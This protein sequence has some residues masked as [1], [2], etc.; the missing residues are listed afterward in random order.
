MKKMRVARQKP[1]PD[2]TLIAAPIDTSPCI[3][4]ITLKSYLFYIKANL[5]RQ[6]YQVDLKDYFKEGGAYRN[7]LSSTVAAKVRLFCLPV[8]FGNRFSAFE[9]LKRVQTRDPHKKII[10]TGPFARIF[11]R[12]ILKKYSPDI[13]IMDDPE[14][15]LSR[16]LS[17]PITD[18]RLSTIENIAYRRGDRI[19][20]NPKRTKFDINRLPFISPLFFKDGSF[21]VPLLTSRGCPYPCKFCDKKSFWGEGMRLR[22]IDNVIEE[23]RFLRRRFGVRKVFFDDCNFVMTKKRTLEFCRKMNN[24]TLGVSWNCTTRVDTVDGS[25]LKL[26]RLAG[27]ETV[28]F[29]VESGSESVLKNIGKD[30][31]V[32]AIT[33]AVQSARAAGLKIGIFLMLGCPGE[34][35]KT[36]QETIRLLREIYPFD[37]LNINPMVILPGTGFCEDLIKKKKIDE[38]FFMEKKDI[39]FYNAPFIKSF[40]KGGLLN[41]FSEVILETI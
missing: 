25:L 3:N 5:E 23:I 27:C 16:I 26:M 17:K 41:K 38:G 11:Y 24:A 22:S 6:G 19:I 35:K 36:F 20:R 4:L 1:M 21:P 10:L 18:R 8:F 15:I 12:E 31:P 9:F 7:F 29:G 13:I 2:I 40:K 32:S 14:F 33:K 30:Y 34:N 39:L 28:Y 37:K